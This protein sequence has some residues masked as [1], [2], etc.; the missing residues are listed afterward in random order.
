MTATTSSED[1]F[2]RLGDDAVVFRG[3]RNVVERTVRYPSGH[4]VQFHLT[5]QS[6]PSN[7]AVL[8]LA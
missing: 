5:E 2:E 7:R 6:G 1:G 3:W 8:V 4:A